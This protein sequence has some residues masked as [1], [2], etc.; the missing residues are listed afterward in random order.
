[1]RTLRFAAAREVFEESNV[2]LCD[3][4]VPQELLEKWRPIVLKDW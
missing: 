3:P 4:I 1:M 2:L